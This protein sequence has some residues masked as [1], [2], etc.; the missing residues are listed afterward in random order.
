MQSWRDFARI[1]AG[2]LRVWYQVARMRQVARGLALAFAFLASVGVCV[3]AAAE[4]PAD[5]EATL[6]AQIERRAA[7]ARTADLHAADTAL[8]F[9]E[10]ERS[11]LGVRNVIFASADLIRE[12]EVALAAGE[13]GRAED[14]AA[15]ATRLS[16]DLAPGYWMWLRAVYADDWTRLADEATV[17]W[18]Y[19][20]AELGEFRNRQSAASWAFA[21]AMW[22]GGV[23]VLLFSFV[24]LLRYLA[25][26]A[27]DL[28]DLLPV[29]FGGRE[30]FLA[31]SLAFALL[32]ILVSPGLAVAAA[33]A[34]L[35]AYQTGVER[36]LS[37][38][39]GLFL[40][41]A[42]V[43]T[44]ILGAPLVA[45]HG[46][47]S[48]VLA[49]AESQVLLPHEQQQ[50]GPSPDQDAL[51][52][53]ILAKR[54]RL[55]GD[56]KGAEAEYR[57]ALKSAADDPLLENNLGAV[58]YADKRFEEA[59][60]HLR[61]GAAGRTELVPMLNL[62]TLLNE[63]AKFKEA[64]ELLAAARAL[65]PERTA[66]YVEA[67]GAA[68]TKPR[69]IHAGLRM[70]V[71]WR[72]LYK[73]QDPVERREITSSLWGPVRGRL[74]LLSCGL[75]VLV[76]FVIG[77]LATRRKHCQP[78]DRCGTPVPL[79]E[80]TCYACRA[81]YSSGSYVDNEL[82]IAKEAQL[83]RRQRRRWWIGLGLSVI[84]G[85][86][87]MY[88][89]HPLRGALWL[90]VFLGLLGLGLQV[91]DMLSVNAW[92]IPVDQG[93]WRWISTLSFGCAGLMSL[94]SVVI[95]ARSEG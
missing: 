2:I 85:L 50:L 43:V 63:R 41:L 34:L 75:G 44:Y 28:A 52:A 20:G 47:R 95:G 53:A 4:E 35:L 77:V 1:L 80:P 40:L 24:Q 76:L 17:A 74:S 6:Q 8:A 23:S 81:V 71:M 72:R 19:L 14:L 49:A 27:H 3:S 33:L 25:Y 79:S 12:A 11:R 22:V 42:P 88:R 7:S 26:A 39:V 73:Q 37:L 38:L 9:I 94:I 62:I 29:L 92:R 87:R 30:V 90:L 16:P 18:R 70:G 68:G 46:S 57:R 59:E 60:Q 13:V 45:F 91:G 48:D 10:E 89:G 69:M 93:L 56:L 15:A 84:A 58:L 65:D 82:R 83:Y 78:C 64:E 36:A 21:W 51:G 31:L 5:T 54:L 55:R 67:R 61:R 86:G 32:A 66:A